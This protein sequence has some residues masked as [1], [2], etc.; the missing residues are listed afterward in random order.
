[1]VVLIHEIAH[2]K[3]GEYYG[4]NLTE[5]ELFPF[6]GV[7]KIEDGLGLD[8]FKEMAISIAGPLSNFI[9][10]V[11]GYFL[12]LYLPIKE[13][14]LNI[15]L[16]A[17]F[18]IFIF[19]LVPIIP[20]DGGRIFRAFLSYIW[21]MKK[22]TS[23]TVFIGKLLSIVMLL[24]GIYYT[25]QSHDN[26]YLIILAGF[27]YF[28]AHRERKLVFFLFIKDVL[29]KKRTLQNKGVMNAKYLTVMETVDLNRVFQEFSTGRYHFVTVISGKGEILG[30]LT[31]GQILDAVGNYG[32]GRPIGEL[33]RSKATEIETF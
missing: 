25:R 1:M 19:N 24:V 11:S 7:V 33:L 29:R 15:F 6:G 18:M 14:L 12:G 5:I 23:I 20:L 16:T 10:L 13:D 27:L 28:N 32:N 21:G 17:N 26:I 22:A 3:V 30:T 31:E 8:P 2:Y 9:L 4:V